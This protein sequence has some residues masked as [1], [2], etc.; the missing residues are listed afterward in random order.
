[1]QEIIDTGAAS[2]GLLGASVRD[3]TDASVGTVGAQIQ[4]LSP[5]GAAEAA[6]LRAGDVITAVD[7]APVTNAVDATAQVRAHAGGTAVTITY[8]RDGQEGEA[9]ATLGTLE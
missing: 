9:E 7:G 1:M 5:G 6:G 4:E 3:V 8:V 2:H